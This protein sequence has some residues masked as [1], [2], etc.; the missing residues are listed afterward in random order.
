MISV[1]ITTHN[2][3]AYIEAQLRSILDQIGADDEVIL[4][5]D[6]STDDT[7]VRV[8]Q[9]ND[10]RIRVFHHTPAPARFANDYATH[11]FEYA[12]RHAQGEFIFL[13]DQ[14]DVWLPHKVAT[15]LPLLQSHLLAVSDCTLTDAQ[16]HPTQPSYFALRPF[17]TS[18]WSNVRQCSFLGSCMAFRRELLTEALPF[19]RYGVAHDLWLGLTAL[20]QGPVAV[21]N[22]P[23]M[24]YRRHEETVTAHISHNRTSL[25]FK[26]HYRLYILRAVLVRL[27]LRLSFRC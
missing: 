18:L 19:P 14:D 15:L 10:P 1:C 23:L 9:L 2:G 11:N 7:L 21:V 16:L 22:K 3:A 8:E 25:W 13:S 6:A 24:F 27:C 20:R 26:L 12:L 5:D 4:S 17:S